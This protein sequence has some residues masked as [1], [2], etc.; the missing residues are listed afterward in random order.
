MV[1]R[2]TIWMLTL[3]ALLFALGGCTASK[4]ESC[5]QD[6]DCAVGLWCHYSKNICT[7]VT[8]DPNTDKCQA[9]EED[10]TGYSEEDITAADVTEDQSSP[11]D[12]TE[13]DT[14]A[15]DGHSGTFHACSSSSGTTWNVHSFLVS[16]EA[17]AGTG[18][19]IDENQDTCSPEDICADGVDNSFA[20]LSNLVN[21]FMIAGIEDGEILLAVHQPDAPCA[22]LTF[23]KRTNDTNVSSES[24]VNGDPVSLVPDLLWTDDTLQAG[25]DGSFRMPLAVFGV[26]LEVDLL[27]VSVQG[28][29]EG[30]TLQLVIGGALPYEA[31]ESAIFSI[32]TESLPSTV[33]THQDI[34]DIIEPALKTDIDID[35]DGTNESISI[36]LQL[37]ASISDLVFPNSLP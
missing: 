27:Q 5:E 23:L 7:E 25:P 17:S 2:R 22:G 36:A 33:E 29:A 15:P 12:I 1:S 18:L 13:E 24:Y 8:C 6:S 20:L 14:W 30:E 16:T 21:T 10:G 31:L 4:G 28:N 19:N 35:G 32:P 11:P 37:D 3:C 9:N 34:M 26:L